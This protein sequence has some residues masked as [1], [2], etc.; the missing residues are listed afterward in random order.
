MSGAA[1]KL[2][3]LVRSPGVRATK[4]DV[5]GPRSVFVAAVVFAAFG[6]GSLALG[7]VMGRPVAALGLVPLILMPALARHPVAAGVALACGGLI[8]RVA[9]IGTGS[10]TDQI[11]TTQAALSIALA[12]DN[13]YGYAIPGTSTVS[14]FPYGPVALVAYIPGVWTEV[15]AG[16]LTMLVLARER[17]PVAVAIYAAFPL[18]VRGT[19]MG[20]NDVLPGLLVTVAVL[21]IAS[22]PMWAALV[23]ALAAAIKPYALAWAP[24]LFGAGGL[25][26]A[27]TF[28]VVSLLAWSPVLWWGPATYVRSIVL[29]EALHPI[30]GSV[31]DLR[32]GRLLALPLSVL[33]FA[34]AR[35]FEALVLSGTLV[36]GSVMLLSH[37]ISFTYLLAP[38]P[39]LLIVAERWLRARLSRTESGA[40]TG[41]VA[42]SSAA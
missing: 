42:S 39:L 7:S 9:L 22:R 11:E 17:V 34:R 13:P 36:F 25:A 3:A 38:L 6:V 37:W 15:A 4:P 18:V 21:L 16:L 29:A 2:E 10:L 23:L 26:A 27:V 14:P 12:G 1:G 35:S 30:P 40:R 32:V 41:P 31:T 5:V 33:A 20:T 19:I 8:F 24:G 28:I